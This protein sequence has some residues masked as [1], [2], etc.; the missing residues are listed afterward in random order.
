MWT[1]RKGSLG[2]P[3]MSRGVRAWC[4]MDERGEG[5]AKRIDLSKTHLSNH[6]SSSMTPTGLFPFAY[7]LQYPPAKAQLS[8][9]FV[10]MGRVS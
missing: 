3:K 7:C 5:G 4:G 9:S 10:E 6:V 8:A 1:E 2:S